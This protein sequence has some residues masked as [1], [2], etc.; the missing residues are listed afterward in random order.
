MHE[1]IRRISDF[2][3]K[4]EQCDSLASGHGLRQDYEEAIDCVYLCESIINQLQEN[5]A[6]KDE[7]IISLEKRLVEM[8]LELANF[9]AL[10]DEHHLSTRSLE[11]E[12]LEDSS[13]I[14]CEPSSI[15]RK[16][17]D[18]KL[19]LLAAAKVY[20]PAQNHRRNKSA[21]PDLKH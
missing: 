18:F 6:A 3:T 16:G 9:K 10:D 20:L 15:D 7:Q 8:S 1:A 17:Q 13:D 19:N 11:I 12:N 2:S 5:L 4:A 21:V 14:E